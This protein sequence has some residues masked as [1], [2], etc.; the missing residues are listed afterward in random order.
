M[1]TTSHRCWPM[2]DI[3][4]LVDFLEL[5]SQHLQ[6]DIDLVGAGGTGLTLL[7]LKASTLDIDFTGP[8]ASIQ[9]FKE[10]LDKEPHGYKVD[11]WDE[12]WVFVTGLP[13][14]YFEKAIHVRDVGHIRLHALHP[15]D[16]VVTKIGRFDVRDQEDILTAVREYG[17][18]AKQIQARASQIGYAA[19]D[20][21]YQH[22]LDVLLGMLS[23]A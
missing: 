7:G 2:L 17:V 8:A 14:D 22:N 12:G 10:A 20:A 23:E 19:N 3:E 11:V 4:D 6:Q 18:T 15:V 9:A 16:I 5:I 1:K 21:N 13:Q